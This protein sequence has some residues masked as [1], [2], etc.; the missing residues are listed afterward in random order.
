M[1]AKLFI[2][3]L[4][5]AFHILCPAQTVNITIDATSNLR[6]ISP[7][8]YGKNNC[9]S[10]D[11]DK[12]LSATKWQFLKDAGV[13]FFRENGG[14]N[15][16]K[17]NW[18]LKLSSHPDWYNNVY[19]H[20][21]D[22][23]AQ[24]LQSNIPGA[25][26]MYAFQLIGKVASNTKNNFN[27]WNYNGSSWWEG[28]AQNLAGGGIINSAGGSDAQKEGNPDLYLMNWN[29]DSTT[30]ILNQWFGSNGIGLNPDQ[31]R[32]WN[33]DNEPEIWNGTH[34]DVIPEQPTAEEFMQR[35]FAVA[36]KARELFPDI[37]LCG[38]VPANEWQWYNYD[39]GL[40]SY[41]GKKYTWLEFFIKRVA[42]E[43][44][45]TGIRLLD[46]IDLHFYPYDSADKDIVQLY[47][48]FFDKNYV[49]PKANGSKILNGIWDEKSNK[50]YILERCRQ[51]LETYMGAG[52]GVTFGI[53]E[54]GIKDRSASVNAVTY[55]SILGTFANNGVEYLTPW[56]WIKGMWETLHLFS[57]YSH[58][59]SCSSVSGD[60]NNLSA[61]TSVSSDSMTII[62]VNRSTTT[63]NTS[64]VT[65]QNSVIADGSY[66]TLQLKDL[67][68]TESFK[69]HTDNAL[70]S[71]SVMVSG[72]NFSISLPPLTI[73][74]ILL[75]GNTPLGLNKIEK[76]KNELYYVNCDDSGK[77]QIHFSLATESTVQID[78]F[79]FQG[80][81]ISG[82]SSRD[83]KCGFHS[84]S[85]NISGIKPGIYFTC[86]NDFNRIK[87][88]KIVLDGYN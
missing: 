56:S 15:A 81:R 72:K 7:G 35:Y 71:G 74:A 18:R 16:T 58:E 67:P 36:K 60:E 10:D 54:L 2:M 75:K 17:Y 23:S 34:D 80:Q 77:L 20:N 86:L 28:V 45:A 43:Q 70:K 57:R 24:Q 73:T 88:Q 82:I 64:Q 40:I 50:E 33:M 52:N 38:P 4:F 62:L 51:W 22:Y 8:I 66:Q 47:R 59:Y 11:P 87:T 63:T 85:L 30:G 31:F 83:Y 78:L 48:V 26:G 3:P 6:P 19:K 5:W 13:K 69:S 76:S 1:K 61:Y 84:E 14:N 27:D 39:T 49:Y 42:E 44:K 29:A 9:L 53:S 46:V 68:G 65:I 21:W 25:H 32:Y 12:P 55:A 41:N 79:D 37:E